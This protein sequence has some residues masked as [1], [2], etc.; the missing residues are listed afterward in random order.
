MFDGTN[1]QTDALQLQQ[2]LLAK[3]EAARK[4]VEALDY[5]PKAALAIQSCWRGHC[6]RAWRRTLLRNAMLED[7][8]AAILQAH[9]RSRLLPRLQAKNDETAAAIKLQAAW[10]RVDAKAWLAARRAHA[11]AEREREAREQNAAVCIQRIWKG[12]YAQ[13]WRRATIALRRDAAATTIAACWHGHR[14]RAWRRQVVWRHQWLHDAATTIQAGWHGY[15]GRLLARHYRGYYEATAQEI[16]VLQIQRAYLQYDSPRKAAA[17]RALEAPSRTEAEQKER[18]EAEMFATAAAHAQA[19]S[20]AAV[21]VKQAEAAIENVAVEAVAKARALMMQ[22][23]V[24]QE[25][26]VEVEEPVAVVEEKP[27][28]VVV[29]LSPTRRKD[30]EEA[31]AAVQ[32]MVSP[33]EASPVRRSFQHEAVKLQAVVRGRL[34]RT[35]EVLERRLARARSFTT[36][37]EHLPVRSGE[38][39]PEEEEEEEAPESEQQKP[40]ML[41]NPAKCELTLAPT[42]RKDEEEA[43]EEEE[44]VRDELMREQ[45]PAAPPPQPTPSSPPI[46]K[47]S[48][49]QSPISDEEVAAREAAQEA[50]ISAAIELAKKEQAAKVAEKEAAAATAA[51]EEALAVVQEETRAAE[52][53][54]KA[55]MEAAEAAEARVKAAEADRLNATRLATE[56]I[57]AKA[58]AEAVMEAVATEAM[59]KAVVEA[60]LQAQVARAEEAEARAASAMAVAKEAENRIAAAEAEAKAKAEKAAEERAAAVAAAAQAAKKEAEEAAAADLRATRGE[61]FE[62]LGEDQLRVEDDPLAQCHYFSP[63]E[64]SEWRRAA[65]AAEEPQQEERYDP[66][67]YEAPQQHMHQQQAHSSNDGAGRYYEDVGDAEYVDEYAPDPEAAAELARWRAKEKSPVR[68]PQGAARTKRFVVEEEDDDEYSQLPPQKTPLPRGW[69]VANDEDGTP[70]YYH[71]VSGAVSWVPPDDDADNNEWPVDEEEEEASVEEVEDEV[72]YYQQQRSQPAPQRRRQPQSRGAATSAAVLFDDESDDA[73]LRAFSMIRR[74]TSDRRRTARAIERGERWYRGIGARYRR[75]SSL[76]DALPLLRRRTAQEV[77]MRE[78]A[79]ELHELAVACLLSRAIKRWYSHTCNPAAQVAEMR[80]DQRMEL[81]IR[82]RRQRALSNGLHEMRDVTHREGSRSPVIDLAVAHAKSAWLRKWQKR[83]KLLKKATEGRDQVFFVL[84]GSSLRRLKS[85]LLHQRRRRA[86]EKRGLSM[87]RRGHLHRTIAT[88]LGHSAYTNVSSHLT[89]LADATWADTGRHRRLTTAMAMWS[90]YKK[91]YKKV[92]AY[93]KYARDWKIGA[94]RVRLHAWVWLHF[95]AKRISIASRHVILRRLA[96]S[97]TYLREERSRAR[98]IVRLELVGRS[99]AKNLNSL[100]VGRSFRQWHATSLFKKENEGKV[101]RYSYAWVPP[102]TSQKMHERGTYS[103]EAARQLAAAAAEEVLVQQKHTQR[104]PLPPPVRVA[105]AQEATVSACS[106]FSRDSPSVR[107]ATSTTSTASDF[108]PSAAAAVLAGGLPRP[109]TTAY[110]TGRIRRGQPGADAPV[111]EVVAAA[112]ISALPQSTTMH[113]AAHLSKNPSLVAGARKEALARGDEEARVQRARE[114]QKRIHGRSW[115]PSLSQ[116]DKHTNDP[117]AG[118]WK[119]NSINFSCNKEGEL[120]TRPATIVATPLQER[121]TPK[122]LTYAERETIKSPPR[123]G[124]GGSRNYSASPAKVGDRKQR[125]RATPLREDNQRVAS[126]W[127]PQ[128][129]EVAWD[130]RSLPTGVALPMRPPPMMSDDGPKWKYAGR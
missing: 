123:S 5:L 36:S 63:S 50:A 119:A 66:H 71:N 54:A 39:W 126:G 30:E 10:R 117:G 102:V 99:H 109:G 77:G 129:E 25:P 121:Y 24:Q 31:L 17:L 46:R 33:D 74:V 61:V 69:C 118:R 105:A 37:Y 14:A 128:G 45:A 53:R 9:T 21:A 107:P 49:T 80:R 78:H 101:D 23:A 65:L 27:V 51:A 1:N 7:N 34:D 104:H 84:L 29:E 38:I 89:M 98:Q 85:R 68:G 44:V 6:A 83:L 92:N 86:L 122:V 116:L 32:A 40:Q 48:P 3:I 82:G 96:Y 90:A 60:E 56:E 12:H 52:A 93:P 88:W 115:T 72:A 47:A 18:E 103:R 11:A 62:D 127:K 26:V 108:A 110:R 112:A 16:A 59:A 20:A 75:R 19:T 8:A 58:T 81:L 67:S 111:A 79:E 87:H 42:R 55:A 94:L 2:I 64:A 22:S 114:R 70:Y 97:F 130:G 57:T 76:S 73:L 113:V 4:T 91:V 35:N 43:P 95:S 28:A 13:A 124:K 125:P 41:F 15:Q 106:L 120:L 100:R